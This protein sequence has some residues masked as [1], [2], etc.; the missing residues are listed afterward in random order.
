M[1]PLPSR[2]ADD[3]RRLAR[4]CGVQTAYYDILRRRVEVPRD[5]LQ[6]VLAAL[7]EPADSPARIAD[8]LRERERAADMRICEPV[9]VAWQGE[10]R[11][12]PLRL[13][14]RRNNFV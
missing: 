1:R 2:T 5:T 10:R 4:A 14:E 6:G 3:L 9:I 8:A 11:A 13:P 12:V 7:G